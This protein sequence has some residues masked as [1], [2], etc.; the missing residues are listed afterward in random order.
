MSD[1]LLELQSTYRRL[2]LIGL[3]VLL[4]AFGLLILKPFGT[5]SLIVGAILFL[6]AMISLELAR[7]IA[8]RMA[9]MVLNDGDRK[10]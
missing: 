1:G 5:A 7:R 2:M 10:A 8:Q 3:L 4:L 9:L 6:V